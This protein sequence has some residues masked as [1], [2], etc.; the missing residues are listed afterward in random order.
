[1]K[2]CIQVSKVKRILLDQKEVIILIIYYRIATPIKKGQIIDKNIN[3]LLWD[4]DGKGHE[5]SRTKS[6]SGVLEID[7]QKY[8]DFFSRGV[9]IGSIKCVHGYNHHG[10]R[11]V[12]IN[13]DLS[14]KLWPWCESNEDWEYI[15]LC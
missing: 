3:S 4:L 12:K 6:I 13:M 14:S 7:Q 2:R 9:G 1:M 10:Q 15:I 8:K 11:S 5:K